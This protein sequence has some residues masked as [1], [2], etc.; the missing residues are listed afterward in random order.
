M[1][2]RRDHTCILPTAD[3]TAAEPG[4]IIACACG[5]PAR[6][7]SADPPWAV[8][9]SSRERRRWLKVQWKEQR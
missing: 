8:A 9:L 3:I 2:L 5:E 6:V 4:Q 1:K 7:E